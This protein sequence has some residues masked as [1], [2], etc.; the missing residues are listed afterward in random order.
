MEMVN[1]SKPQSLSSI[2]MGLCD[3]N[4]CDD[5]RILDITLDSRTVK[6]GSCFMSVA[7]T[8]EVCEQHVKDGIERGAAAILCSYSVDA[9]REG[10]CIIKIDAL[11]DHLGTISNRF[12]NNP[13]Y[14]LKVCATTGTDGKTTVAYLT[15]MAIEILGG[16]CGYVGTLGAGSIGRL[17]ESKNTSPDVISIHRWLARFRDEGFQFASIEAS[18]HGLHQGRLDG[19]KLETASFTNLSRDHLDYHG[20]MDAYLESKSLLFLR[21]EVDQCIINIDDKA[22]RSIFEHVPLHLKTWTCSSSSL[23][24]CLQSERQVQASH[25]LS[26]ARGSSFTLSYEKIE[27]KVFS[28]LIGSFNVD[29]LLIVVTTLLA[30]GYLFED[31]CRCIPKLDKIPGRM[32]LCGESDTGAKVYVDYAHTPASLRAALQAI[33]AMRPTRVSVVFGCGGQRDKGK[34][35]LMGAIAEQLSD[36]VFITADNPRTEAQGAIAADI[37]QRMNE[38][39]KALVIEDR[40]VAICEAIFAAKAGEVVLIAG[41]GHETVQ[42]DSTGVSY[43]SD[44]LFVSEVL[45]KGTTV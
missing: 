38:P 32:E 39:E 29:N 31:I 5:R 41:K 25:S 28:P 13:S 22:G 45:D 10:V 40:R 8:K 44:R 3:V 20:T 18:S 17:V 27:E 21:S 37:L 26:T 34:R 19:V 42:S 43:H 12:F 9:A 30:L 33:T 4:S 16:E 2:L 1:V 35:A 14:S 11:R 36:Q 23:S 6:P 7:D 24:E 15:S